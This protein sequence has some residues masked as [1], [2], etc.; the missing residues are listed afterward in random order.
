MRTLVRLVA[1]SWV[2]AVGVV[3]TASAEKPV[4]WSVQAHFPTTLPQVGEATHRMTKMLERLSGGSVRLSIV[5]PGGLTPPHEI[6]ASVSAGALDAGYSSPG[7]WAGHEP[8]LQVFGGLPFGPPAGEF[9]AWFWGGEGKE[10][11]QA[12][13]GQ[14]K[15]HAIPCGVIPPESAGW[16]RKRIESTAALSGLKI[17]IFGLGGLVLGKFGASPQ[18]LPVGDTLPALDRGT[19]DAAELVT[20]SIDYALGL[21]QFA[22]YYYFPGWHQR[23]TFTDLLVNRDSWNRLS[24]RQQELITTVC[25]DNVLY[26]L[27]VSLAAQPAA[28]E[29]IRKKGVKPERLPDEV[30]DALRKAWQEVVAEQRKKSDNFRRAWDSLAAFRVGQDEWRELQRLD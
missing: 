25:A 1:A 17:R 13:Y 20:P 23:T 21:H 12:L 15:V 3:G 8:A 9:F 29:A 2:I 4:R 26:S 11:Y 18:L 14:F 7:F 6:L 10:I 27:A 28:L 19:I 16:Y 30:I 24:S 5:E 22:K